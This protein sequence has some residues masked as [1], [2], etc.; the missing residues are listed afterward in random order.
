MCHRCVERS[1]IT[2]MKIRWTPIE[3]IC[4]EVEKLSPDPVHCWVEQLDGTPRAGRTPDDEDLVRAFREAMLES[5]YTVRVFAAGENSEHVADILSLLVRRE[6]ETQHTVFNMADATARLWKYTNALMRMAASAKVSLDPQTIVT[7]ILSIVSRST[8]L[9]GGVGIL[10][11]TANNGYRSVQGDTVEGID[12]NLVAVFDEISEEVQLVTEADASADLRAACRQIMGH[13]Q[14][15]AVARLVIDADTAG[16]IIAN[17]VDA[18]DA[19]SEDLKVLASAAQM[20]SIAIDNSRTLVRERETTRLQVQNELLAQQNRDMEEMVHVVAHDLRSPMTALYGFVHVA[21]DELKDLRNDLEGEGVNGIGS[22]S[23]LIAEPLRDAIRSVEKLNRMV[24]RLL[25]FSKSARGEYSY[26]TIDVG[27]LVD[28]VVR[29]LRYQLTTKEIEYEVQPLPTIDGDRVQLEAV[30]GNLVDNAIKYM[31]DA[32]EKKITIGQRPG[33]EP[34]YFVR[35][36][37]VGMTPEQVAQ[38]FL[39]FKRFHSDAAP[40]DGIGLPHVRKIIERHGGRIWCESKVGY[41]TTFFFTLGSQAKRNL[42]GPSVRRARQQAGAA[43]A[44][45]N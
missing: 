1:Y 42:P 38:A 22:M 4:R 26:E 23:D 27:Q 30:F 41:G 11:S 40:G 8:R 5:G 37:G 25:E 29:S 21:L 31:S 28:G 14:P 10:R 15:V 2:P 19:I 39:P 24:Q 3:T 34:V 43:E 18:E 12:A 7:N 9:S 44:G 35:D 13:S 36:T 33:P 6:L 32:G 45:R 17:V 16:F 20:I